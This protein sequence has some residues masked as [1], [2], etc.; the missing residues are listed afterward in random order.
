MEDFVKDDKIYST[1]EVAKALR[2]SPVTITRA[3]RDGKLKAFRAGGQWRI[4]GSKVR[5]YIQEQTTRALSKSD[6]PNSDTSQHRP[7]S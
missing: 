5:R 7:S 1:T 3:I 4:L 2:V 6:A